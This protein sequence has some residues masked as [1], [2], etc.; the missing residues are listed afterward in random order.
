MKV[1]RIDDSDK[2][3]FDNLKADFKNQFSKHPECNVAELSTLKDSC[4]LNLM[5]E[6]WEK[7]SYEEVIHK[8]S[9]SQMFQN[10]KKD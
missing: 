2:I 7:T 5:L 3:N 6:L 8:L 1:V 10:F 9:D 4:F